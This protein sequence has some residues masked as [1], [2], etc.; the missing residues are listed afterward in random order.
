MKLNGVGE[1]GAKDAL[2]GD[3]NLFYYP[4]KVGKERKYSSK[5]EEWSPSL[6][7]VAPPP[8]LPHLIDTANIVFK[9]G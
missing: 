7:G 1:W 2:L 5:T 8:P 6:W 4:C 3:G 9:R